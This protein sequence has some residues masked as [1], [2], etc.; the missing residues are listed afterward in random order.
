M[1]DPIT[2]DNRLLGVVTNAGKDVL[3]LDSVSGQEGI[4]QPFRFVLTMMSEVETGNPSKV[5]PHDLVGTSMTVRV[6]LS[7][8]GEGLE[9]GSRYWTGM[10]E[11]F[12]QENQDEQFAYFSAV[13]CR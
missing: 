10:C 1:G 11:R 8:P 13:G 12:V 5:K 4:S 2:Q 7:D 6:S 9:S 3:L